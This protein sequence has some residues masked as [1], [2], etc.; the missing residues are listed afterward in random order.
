M[1]HKERFKALM[2]GEKVDR[3][4][5]YF[6]GTWHETKQRWK[7]EGCP[8]ID[9]I[10][11]DLGP[12]V[13]GMD[14]DWEKG[15]WDCHGLVNIYAITPNKEEII[16]ETDSYYVVK[17]SIGNVTK[18]SKL[19][20]SI[21]QVLEN[22]LKPNRESWEEF[23]KFFDPHDSARYAEN[24][25][26]KA[27]K[28]NK[29]DR[30]LTFMGGS[31]YGW[32]RDFMGVV[33]L[34]MLMYDDPELFEEIISYFTDYFI[35]VYT[36]IV[37][38]VNF[39]FVY[40]WEDCCGADGPLFSP[41]IYKEFYHKYYKKLVD[42][43]KSN[44]IEFILI[45]SDG[46]TDALIPCWMESGINVMFPIEVG[47]WEQSP[48]YLR[49]TFGKE[50]KMVGGIDKHCIALGEDAIRKELLKIKDVVEEGGY[51][52]MPDHRIPPEC[53][54]EQFLKYVDVFHEIFG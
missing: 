43:Y 46:K 27:E 44:G 17:S 25:E 35:E 21:E 49:K 29:E 34:S 15:M 54:Y 32:L 51:L 11:T 26:E 13:E 6:F 8:N 40:I 52:P 50:L 14:P 16:E 28:L 19:G 24:W 10:H 39:D 18:H 47:K 41:A 5:L 22:G 4:P 33:E 48:G 31:L 36:P 37:K 7:D 53:S 45:D 38:K 1:T 23:K 30:V 42:F 2:K 20:S 3:V 12:Q 9:V